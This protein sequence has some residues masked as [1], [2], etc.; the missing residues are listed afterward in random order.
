MKILRL[1]QKMEIGFVKDEQG[2]IMVLALMM[3]VI[4]S[5]MG[6]AA[7]MVRNTEQQIT[8][9]TEVLHHNFFAVE[10]VALE[11]AARI[12]KEI[13]L[14][15]DKNPAALFDP[16]SFTS[17]PSWM[18]ADSAALDLTQS[19]QWPSPTISP[20]NTHLTGVADITPNGYASDG[21]SAG[22][23]IWYAVEEGPNNGRCEGT[24][25]TQEDKVEMC[26]S[27]YGMYDVKAGAG[28]TY[29]GR[30]LLNVGYKKVVYF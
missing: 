25:L 3:L 4:L 2:F 28:K 29:S 16:L 17:F 23:R 14:Y 15:N 19:S 18:R 10:A 5:I 1:G 21:T 20:E 30:R 24:S 7:M 12:N 11:G 27:I 26:Y 8:V 6:S 13:D 9:N 22:D